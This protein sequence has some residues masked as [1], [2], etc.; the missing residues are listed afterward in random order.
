MAELAV[1]L[2]MH[3]TFSDGHA[4]HESI[5]RIALQAG[6][7]AIITTDHN[8]FVGGLDRYITD[9]G[10]KLLLMVGEE[11]HDVQRQPQKN[12]L[13]VF[14]ANRELCAYASEPQR[15]VYQVGQAGGLAFIAHPIDPPLAAFKEDDLSWVDWDL[16]GFHGLELWNGYSE[17]KS[18]VRFRLQGLFYAYFPNLIARGALPATLRLWDDLHRRGLRIVAIGGSDAHANPMR[19]GPL[20]RTIFPYEFHFRAVNTH[21]ITPTALTD[22][23]H[24]DRHMILDALRDGHAFVGYDLPASTR[25]FGFSARGKSKTVS[26]GDELRFEDGVTFQIRLPLPV[27]CCLLR[28]GQV[29]KRWKDRE[30][31]TYIA[32]QPGVYRVECYIRYFGR[33]RGWIYSN[34]IY[35]RDA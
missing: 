35:I 5:A 27:E 8:I 13:L 29:I 18:V 2:H 11:I 19:M 31:I 1:N 34:P 32:T 30:I 17:V 25:G 9:K 6:L 26:M 15:L 23:L 20:R 10:R 16:H 21:L 24:A 14:G 22:D 7:D 33:R 12:H 4:S 3:T 28:D